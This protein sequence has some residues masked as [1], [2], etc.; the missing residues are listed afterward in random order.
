MADQAAKTVFL[1]AHCGKTDHLRTAAGNRGAARKTS[2]AE[3][4]A[5]GRRRDGQGERDANDDRYGD[6]HKEGLEVGCPH[7]E[8]AERAGCSADAGG[9]GVREQAA[10]HDGDERRDQ[11]VDLGGARNQFAALG[12]DDS[13]H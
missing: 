3:C 9:D 11:N 2:Q 4:G 7:D 13:N 5:D 6:A 1:E 12:C 10:H 8:G